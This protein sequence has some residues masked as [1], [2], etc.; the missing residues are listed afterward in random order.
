[1]DA[2]D[3]RSTT[4]R[5]SARPRQG[6]SMGDVARL[7]GVSSQTVSRVSNGFAGVNEDTRETV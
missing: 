7:A 3:G 6:P 5:R 1:M 2:T 4:R